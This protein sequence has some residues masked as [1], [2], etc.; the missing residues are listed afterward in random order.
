MQISRT[1]MVI[2]VISS[3]AGLFLCWCA[4]GFI[5]ALI[6][7]P[8]PTHMLWVAVALLGG[9]LVGVGVAALASVFPIRCLFQ[10]QTALR[11][12]ILLA[13]A[14]LASPLS[15]WFAARSAAEFAYARFRFYACPSDFDRCDELAD[16]RYAIISELTWRWMVPETWRQPCYSL[17]TA[18]C[19]L[20]DFAGGGTFFNTY[21][22]GAPPW[23]ATLALGL[24]SVP[25]GAGATILFTAR[26]SVV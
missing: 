14:L 12:S 3:L 20:A 17:S 18:V 24:L 21:Y 4:L 9:G 23:G 11:I 1:A 15:F 7:P 5:L 10:R 8:L 16:N 26:R 13:L 2:V 22:W 19:E 25:L 6:S